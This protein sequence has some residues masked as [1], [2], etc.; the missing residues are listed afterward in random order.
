MNG[1]QDWKHVDTSEKMNKFEL[2]FMYIG[3]FVLFSSL[4]VLLALWTAP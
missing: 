1:Y 4:V 3:G 2:A